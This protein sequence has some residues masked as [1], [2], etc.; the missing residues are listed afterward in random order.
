MQFR[1]GSSIVA[2]GGVWFGSL[3]H[4]R[5]VQTAHPYDNDD[6]P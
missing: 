6:W 1:H 3:D 2:T 5:S 4:R